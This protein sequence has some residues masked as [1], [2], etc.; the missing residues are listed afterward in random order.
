MALI[1]GIEVGIVMHYKL[2]RLM[3]CALF[4]TACTIIATVTYTGHCQDLYKVSGA[5]LKRVKTQ[6]QPVIQLQDQ[7]NLTKVLIDHNKVVKF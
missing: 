5:I 1:V 2:L 3:Q 6:Q 4:F 7:L